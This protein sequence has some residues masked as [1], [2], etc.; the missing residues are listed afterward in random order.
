MWSSAST[1]SEGLYIFNVVLVVLNLGN[2]AITK[3]FLLNT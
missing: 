1:G 3:T 2:A